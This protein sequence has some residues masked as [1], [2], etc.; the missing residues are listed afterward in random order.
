M[1]NNAGY[2]CR[3]VDFATSAL[4]L[5][6]KQ[7]VIVINVYHPPHGSLFRLEAELFDDYLSDNISSANKKFLKGF[8]CQQCA[9]SR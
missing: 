3:A 4:F 2:T 9:H 8:R 5:N 6:L 7:A 1:R